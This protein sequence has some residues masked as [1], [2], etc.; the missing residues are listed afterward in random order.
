MGFDSRLRKLEQAGSARCR[1]CHTM[2]VLMQVCND[3]P[4]LTP[5]SLTA[6]GRCPRCG[7]EAKRFHIVTP[8]TRG[9]WDEA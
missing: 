4:S 2:P 6:D 3:P 8:M 5:K 7:R 9:D 1:E